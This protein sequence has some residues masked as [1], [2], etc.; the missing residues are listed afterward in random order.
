MDLQV[1]DHLSIQEALPISSLLSHCDITETCLD[2]FL[3]ICLEALV[4][5]QHP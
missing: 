4:P 5:T 3:Q 2:T 1:A